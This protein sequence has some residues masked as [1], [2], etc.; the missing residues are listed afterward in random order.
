MIVWMFLKTILISRIYEKI[1]LREVTRKLDIL[2]ISQR[3][4]ILILSFFSHFF[5]DPMH[6]HNEPLP[7]SHPSVQ[8][9][10]RYNRLYC[11]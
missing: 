7:S 6:P 4:E 9:F 1:S 10:V 2:L 3:K 8:L 11:P 5:L